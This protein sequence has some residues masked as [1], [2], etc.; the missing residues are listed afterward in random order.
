MNPFRIDPDAVYHDRE[1]RIGLNL[2]SATLARA[3]RNK[4]LRFSRQGHSVL[5]RGQW[6]IDWLESTAAALASGEAAPC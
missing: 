5:Y 2:S 4:T 3:R 6:L 1:V